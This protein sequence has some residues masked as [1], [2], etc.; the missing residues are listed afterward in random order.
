[1]TLIHSPSLYQINT[2]IWLRELSERANRSITLAEVPDREL[3]RLRDFGF[4][5]VWLLGIWQ[6]G[7][8]G[9][10]VAWSLP[11]LRG[12]FQAELQ[13]VTDADIVGSPFAIQSY[14]VHGDFGGPDTLPVIR[15]RLRER[16]IR[17]MLDFVPNHTALDHPWVW[18]HPEYYVHG[19]NDDLRTEPNNYIRIATRLG[20][21]VLAHGR[22]PYFP[23]WT[24]TLQLNYRS[25]ALRAAMHVQL[26]A[27][28]ALCDGVRC[29]MAMLLLP[30]VI[31][32]TW[33]HRS[34]P[35][36]GT[37]LIDTSFWAEAIPRIRAVHASFCFMA[38]VYWDLEWTLQRQ[39]FDYTYDKRLYDRLVSGN[40]GEVRGHL[41][42]DTAFQR[43]SVRFLENHDEPRAARIFPPG[44]HEAAATTAFLTQGLRFFYD[45]QLEGRQVRNSIQLARRRAEG[46]NSELVAFYQTLL[47]TLRGPIVREGAWSMLHPVPA[48]QGSTAHEGFISFLWQLAGRPPLLFTVNY[49][50]AKGQCYVPIPLPELRTQTVRLAD[51]FSDARYD[52]SG[53]ELVEHGLY[54]DV[55]GW[56]YHVFDVHVIPKRLGSNHVGIDR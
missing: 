53:S 48:W 29:D 23:G 24:D 31:E 26:Q 46:P 34:N 16:N 37:A 10:L 56:H 55:P 44:V 38:E 7:P 41:G 36:G 47:A 18:Q 20:P 11:D 51:R 5:W 21:R 2:R 3:D 1:M 13:N 12:Q 15:R 35:S 45:G 43:S 25:A 28:A 6:T 30:D 8:A 39:G 17:L 32:R 40:A 9:R 19:T 27:I 14:L 50:P 22:D 33:G 42:A 54:L 49:G 4:D 52:R